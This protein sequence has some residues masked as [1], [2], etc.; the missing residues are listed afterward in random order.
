MS[1]QDGEVLVN[2][3]KQH[4]LS[5]MASRSE[6]SSDGAGARNSD[7]EAACGFGL[8]LPQQRGWFTWSLL[9]SLAA[10]GSVDVLRVGGQGVGRYRLKQRQ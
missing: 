6:C 3:C 2:R 5:V 10:E 9:Q 8:D 4:L 7:L 1:T